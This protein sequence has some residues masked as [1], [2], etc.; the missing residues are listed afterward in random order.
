VALHVLLV[1]TSLAAAPELNTESVADPDVRPATAAVTVQLPGTPVVVT[2]ALALLAPAETVFD[3]GATLQ[4]PVLS[5]LNVMFFDEVNDAVAP[6]ASLSVP[7][8][9]VACAEPAG[10]SVWP[11]VAVTDVGAPAAVNATLAKQPV[12][13]SADA[14]S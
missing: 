10:N 7:V 3:A 2:V 4:M 1:I 9:L 6:L 8:T 11:R 12:R 5:T 14:E 13:L